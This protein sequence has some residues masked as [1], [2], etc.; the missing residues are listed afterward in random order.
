V[1]MTSH[2]GEGVLCEILKILTLLYK[3]TSQQTQQIKLSCWRSYDLKTK[4]KSWKIF[5]FVKNCQTQPKVNTFST[6]CILARNPV[7]R[8]GTGVL[9][10]ALTVRPQCYTCQRKKS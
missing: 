1:R 10:F 7:A 8:Q 9:Q 6:S 5:V 4:V 2:D 3:S